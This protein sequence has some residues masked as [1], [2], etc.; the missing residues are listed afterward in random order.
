MEIEVYGDL[1]FL[2]NFSMD[3]LTLYLCAR[4]SARPLRL[5]R[6]LLSA[7]LGALYALAILFLPAKLPTLLGIVADALVCMLLC[8]VGLYQRGESLRVLWRLGAIYILISALLGGIM[9]VLSSA[10]NRV[11][12]QDALRAAQGEQDVSFALF[13]V[14][15]PL[16]AGLC[17]ILCRAHRRAAARRTVL[18]HIVQGDRQC[19]LN[20]LCDS[21]NLLRDPISARPVIPVDLDAAAACLPAPLTAALRDAHPIAR[22]AALPDT[23]MLRTRLIP[24]K[25]ATGEQMLLAYQADHVYLDTGK[26]GRREIVA[27]IA[28]VPLPDKSEYTAIL[29]AELLTR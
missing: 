8:A 26:G 13:S 27:Y 10:L 2:V 22:T 28:P 15:A 7:A 4:L 23:L 6:S 24:A 25:G 12:S 1:L 9:T 20:A 11:V 5:W 19:T 29:P 17:L 21:G 3:F 18:L 16:T 14:L